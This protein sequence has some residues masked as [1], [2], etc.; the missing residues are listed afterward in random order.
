M[1]DARVSSCVC[2]PMCIAY[3]GMA[4]NVDVDSGAGVAC[5]ALPRLLPFAFA[6]LHALS[7]L[8]SP[9]FLPPL[10]ASS[11]SLYIFA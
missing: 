9:L 6:V 8:L 2:V 10:V 3:F 4:A 1:H 11:L 5:L 7:A